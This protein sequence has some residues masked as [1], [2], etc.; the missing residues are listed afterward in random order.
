[1]ISGEIRSPKQIRVNK[2]NARAFV[3]FCVQLADPEELHWQQLFETNFN[4]GIF[5]TGAVDFESA[6][7]WYGDQL[8]DLVD[9]IMVLATCVSTEEQFF[10]ESGI[11]RCVNVV[12]GAKVS[13]ETQKKWLLYGRGSCYEVSG[14]DSVEPPRECKFNEFVE[15]FFSSLNH[16]LSGS[17]KLIPI[18]NCQEC[19]RP[20]LARRWDQ[21]FCNLQHSQKWRARE[22]YRNRKGQEE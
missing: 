10:I 12:H 14:S 2:G 6:W 8:P 3:A 1:M 17:E 11:T 20:F 15:A 19:R 7:E 18:R 16:V 13:G 4:R 9:N 21:K 5:K 22:N